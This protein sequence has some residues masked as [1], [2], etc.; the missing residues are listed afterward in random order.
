MHKAVSLSK[1][2]VR[3]KGLTGKANLLVYNPFCLKP[4]LLET[5]RSAAV[6]YPHRRLLLFAFKVLGVDFSPEPHWVL[7]SSDFG[8][9]LTEAHGHP[10]GLTA[11]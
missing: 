8:S 2:D 3:S 10:A 6:K 4:I 9:Q 7:L 5:P 11:P 1:K